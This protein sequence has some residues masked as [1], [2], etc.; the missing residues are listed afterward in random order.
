MGMKANL[1]HCFKQ[2]AHGQPM[3]GA[4]LAEFEKHLRETIRGEHTLQELAEVY[5]LSEAE[6]SPLQ[7]IANS[8]LGPRC[9]CPCSC[10]ETPHDGSSC[11]IHGRIY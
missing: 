11:E 4:V 1:S 8:V 7:V 5:C 6:P 9:T 3:H 10:D 2:I